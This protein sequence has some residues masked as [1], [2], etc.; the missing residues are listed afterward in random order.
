MMRVSGRSSLCRLDSATLGDPTIKVALARQEALQR[1]ATEDSAAISHE[2]RQ[3]LSSVT[4]SH[5]A[6]PKHLSLA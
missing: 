2:L 3:L 5:V 4:S 6:K 1:M